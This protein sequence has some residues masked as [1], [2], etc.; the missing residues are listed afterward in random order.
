ML[1]RGRSDDQEWPVISVQVSHAN[2]LQGLTY[3]HLIT[4]EHSTEL[5]E[6]KLDPV[7][8]K[9]IQIRL[10]LARQVF[11]RLPILRLELLHIV[12]LRIFDE[13]ATG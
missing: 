11:R 8:L 4:E 2:S 3:A 6:A 1:E 10:D 12:E 7:S 13:L 9:L 5:L